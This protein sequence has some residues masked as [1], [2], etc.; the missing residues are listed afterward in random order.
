MTEDQFIRGA[1]TAAS[2][3]VIAWL[4]QKAKSKLRAARDK[5]GCGIPESIGRR[6]GKLWAR[7]Y[8]AAK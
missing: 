5:R 8:R 6:L 4:L 1:I 3:P 2:L 7:A